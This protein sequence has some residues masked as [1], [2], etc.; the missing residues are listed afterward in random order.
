MKTPCVCCKRYRM[1][2]SHSE[3]RPGFRNL[4][5]TFNNNNNYMYNLVIQT[6]KSPT[7]ALRPAIRFRIRKTIIAFL[8]VFRDVYLNMAHRHAPDGVHRPVAG[9]VSAC[10]AADTLELYPDGYSVE[11][12]TLGVEMTPSTQNRHGIEQSFFFRLTTIEATL[13]SKIYC[14]LISEQYKANRTISMISCSAA[15]STRIL[16]IGRS[17]LLLWPVAKRDD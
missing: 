11:S 3:L 12:Y 1:F 15:D 4:C 17:R 7:N 8:H 10:G 2:Q 16:R 13:S 9:D 6:L 5:S 14:A